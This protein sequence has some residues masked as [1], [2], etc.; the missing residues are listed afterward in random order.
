MH[1]S[2]AQVTEGRCVPCQAG[3]PPLPPATG[4]PPSPGPSVIVV[5]EQD[6]NWIVFRVSGDDGSG[7]QAEPFAARLA[8]GTVV[9]GRLDRRGAVRLEGIGTGEVAFTLPSRDRDGWS[10]AAA[11]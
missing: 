3:Q 4:A 8:D 2:H 6:P 10:R 1:V 11:G 7:L 9:T 5:D